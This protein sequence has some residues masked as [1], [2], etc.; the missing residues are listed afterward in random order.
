M[1]LQ[2][3]PNWPLDHRVP[4]ALVPHVAMTFIVMCLILGSIGRGRTPHFFLDNLSTRAPESTTPRTASKGSSQSADAGK[5]ISKGVHKGDDQ[6]KD[7]NKG[8]T[9]KGIERFIRKK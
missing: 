3:V 1:R 2:Y 7:I 4:L 5:G 8:K 6:G 9:E